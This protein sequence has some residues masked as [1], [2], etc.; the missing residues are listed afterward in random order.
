MSNSRDMVNKA[1][2]ICK[3]KHCAA[4]D[5][6]AHYAYDQMLRRQK[7]KKIKDLVLPILCTHTQN[8]YTKGK[9]PGG[10]TENDHQVICSLIPSSVHSTS[11]R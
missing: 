3:S 11:I 8:A 4:L 5:S 9:T 10:N 2:C 6:D 1:G 7:D